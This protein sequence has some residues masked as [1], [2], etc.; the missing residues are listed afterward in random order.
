MLLV[1]GALEFLFY[2]YR[3]GLVERILVPVCVEVVFCGDKAGDGGR[4]RCASF[5]QSVRFGLFGCARATALRH[6]C[7]TLPDVF[8][9]LKGRLLRCIFL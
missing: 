8:V 9:T 5:A 6:V 2:K 3:V 4:R 7:E 1:D